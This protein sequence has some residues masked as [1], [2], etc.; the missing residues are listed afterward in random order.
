MLLTCACNLFTLHAQGFVVYGN[1]ASLKGKVEL[2]VHD[3]SDIRYSTSIKNGTFSFEGTV[4]KPVVAE[5][6]HRRLAQPLFFYLEN[7]NIKINLN[8]ENPPSSPITGSRTNSEYRIVGETITQLLK[9][10]GDISGVLDVSSARFL[11]HILYDYAPL[12]DFDRLASLYALIDS[13]AFD[14]Y[15]YKLLK[16]HIAKVQAVSEGA[17]MADF[18]FYEQPKKTQHFDSIPLT[19]DYRVV[20]FGAKWCDKCKDV[21]Q[22][23][24]AIDGTEWINIMIDN[25]PKGWDADYLELFAIDHIPFLILLD[26]ENKIIAR[27]V[28]V[29]QLPKLIKENIVR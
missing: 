19:K 12:L 20:C 26:K 1:C 25:D 28:R 10:N 21:E 29:W 4:K 24:S 18:V 8:A 5:I 27:D 15:H 11:P 14:T 6:R 16:Q 9:R 17:K 2:I 23:G 7:N 13:S 22:A 3:N